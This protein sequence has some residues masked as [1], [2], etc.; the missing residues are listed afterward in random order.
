M[1]KLWVLHASGNCGVGNESL[2]DLTDLI[3]LDVGWN[4]KVSDVNHMVQLQSLDASGM[5]G[6]GDNG[7][8]H[9]RNL[10]SLESLGNDKISKHIPKSQQK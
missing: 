6:V 2:R 3:Y 4:R 8:T 1:K 10:T 9:L 5:C 7:L